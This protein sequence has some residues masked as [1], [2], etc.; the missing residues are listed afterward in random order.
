MTASWSRIVTRWSLLFCC[1]SV[2]EIFLSKISCIK[3]SFFPQRQTVV[4]STNKVG[5]SNTRHNIH[6]LREESA[7]C[8][9]LERTTVT[10]PWPKNLVTTGSYFET[11]PLTRD[12]RCQWQHWKNRQFYHRHWRS[13]HTDRFSVTDHW[14]TENT[15]N[16]DTDVTGT[17]T[18]SASPITDALAPLVSLMIGAHWLHRYLVT[19]C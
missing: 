6:R 15:E 12:G 2:T 5:I 13:V 14:N 8:G 7:S 10:G 19:N 17:P 3:F 11:V 1:E 4:G 16:T 18:T 9:K